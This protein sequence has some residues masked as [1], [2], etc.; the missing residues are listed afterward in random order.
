MYVCMRVYVRVHVM[1]EYMYVCMYSAADRIRVGG[2]GCILAFSQKYKLQ[3][4]FQ[5]YTRIVHW[6]LPHGPHEAPIYTNIFTIAGW[7]C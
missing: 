5:S 7:W 4:M 2:Y 1:H 6:R 3:S